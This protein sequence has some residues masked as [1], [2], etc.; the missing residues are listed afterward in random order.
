[1][2]S[3]AFDLSSMG[4]ILDGRLEISR[5]SNAS[6][7]LEGIAV[8]IRYSDHSYGFD[9]ENAYSELIGANHISLLAEEVEGG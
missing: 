3:I 1:M 7:S 5:L 4:E 8:G 2:D 6:I 9:L